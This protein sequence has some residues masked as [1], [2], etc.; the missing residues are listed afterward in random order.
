MYNRDIKYG[1]WLSKE[2]NLALKDL[3]EMTAL[4]RA[5]VLRTLIRQDPLRHRPNVDF[6][7]LVRAVDRVGNNINQCV[8]VIQTKGYASETDAKE[9]IA[10]MQ[11]IKSEV[12]SWKKE[13]L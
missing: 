1:L 7:T 8:K 13:W 3:C 9:L 11:T 12:Y 4:S 5:D 2:D 10:L 6:M